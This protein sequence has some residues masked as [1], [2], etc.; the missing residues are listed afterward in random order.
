MDHEENPWEGEEG[1]ED[2]EETEREA[3]QKDLVDIKVL[4]ELLE[5]RG[6]KGAVFYCP[7]CDEDHYLAWDLLAGNLEEILEAGEPPVHEPAFNPNPENYVSWDFARGFLDGYESYQGEERS[8][9]DE[10]TARLVEALREQDW[11]FPQ[12]RSFLAGVGLDLPRDARPGA[13]RNT[14]EDP[15]S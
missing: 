2:L 3:L 9:Q 6:I 1:A 12:I 10:L 4:K 8:E 5:P 15:G 11:G 14:G 7:D 13:P